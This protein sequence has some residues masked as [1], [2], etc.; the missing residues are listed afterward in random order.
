[1]GWW[2]ESLLKK[3]LT[4]LAM[5]GDSWEWIMGTHHHR[6]CT[7]IRRCWPR[8]GNKNDISEN[9]RLSPG[10]IQISYLHQ[11]VLQRIGFVHSIFRQHFP[12]DCLSAVAYWQQK[13]LVRHVTTQTL[14]VNFQ[15]S[16]G[17]RPAI[18]W[19]ELLQFLFQL[20]LTSP[21]H[22]CFG[23]WDWARERCLGKF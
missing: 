4:H 21:T 9:V 16:T 18:P 11:T 20:L 14:P 3:T 8:S 7:Q 2:K 10:G 1:M 23:I 19:P 17:V 22:H 12:H 13:S 5:S 15:R 6:E